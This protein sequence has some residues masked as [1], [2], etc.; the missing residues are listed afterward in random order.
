[1]P[2]DEDKKSL[3]DAANNAWRKWH[4]GCEEDEIPAMSLAFEKGF[5]Q[6]FLWSESQNH[7][8]E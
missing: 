7:K 3:F 6:G 2:T 8:P 1:M 4:N 5:I